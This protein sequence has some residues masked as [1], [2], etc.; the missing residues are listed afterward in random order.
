LNDATDHGLDRLNALPR[1]V[2][3]TELLQC[4]GSRVWA[5]AMADARPFAD[6][7]ALYDVSDAVWRSLARDDW[8]E[9]FRAHPRIGER[10][11][12][13]H[14]SSAWSEQEQARVL[15]AAADERAELAALN[16]L[17]EQRFGYI[18]LI[19][20]TGLEA[21]EIREALRHRLDNDPADELHIAA[22]EQRRITRLRLER[23]L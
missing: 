20:A 10:A 18:F 4:C 11:S 9:A 16:R 8:L 7:G 19:C 3:V 14:R 22:E 23:L 2:A 21:A 13:E 5:E 15:S 12:V 17:Y 6:R 1:A